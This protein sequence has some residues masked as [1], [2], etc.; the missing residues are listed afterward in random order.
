M[1][2]SALVA[3]VLL[4]ESPE[5]NLPEHEQRSSGAMHKEALRK[6][7]DAGLPFVVS[8]F[9]YNVVDGDTIM[10]RLKEPD[11]DGSREAFRIRFS[12]V[13]APELPKAQG[14]D[15]ILRQAGIEPN[16]D[17]RGIRAREFMKQLLKGRSIFV[18]PLRDDDGI[19]QTDRFGRLLANVVASGTPGKSFVT[20]G[21]IPAQ[22]A[23]YDAGLCE[24]TGEDGLPNPVP[25]VLEAAINR[26]SREM[27]VQGDGPGF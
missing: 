16:P 1:I 8:K 17:H 10:I 2:T 11:A 22:H 12:A 9:D 19:M 18:D 5:Q 6:I 21:M 3:A 26:K 23:L 7:V 4:R 27:R 24:L 25:P 14:T 15:F 13:N 20:T